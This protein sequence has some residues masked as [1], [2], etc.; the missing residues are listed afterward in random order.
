MQL[1]GENLTMARNVST[2]INE[3]MIYLQVC[4]QKTVQNQQFTMTLYLTKIQNYN[5][6][7]GRFLSFIQ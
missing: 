7:V 6:K 1:K 5:E 2:V 4:R 3:V